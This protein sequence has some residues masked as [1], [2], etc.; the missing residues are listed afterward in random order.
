MTSNTNIANLTNNNIS[1][2]LTSI[3]NSNN[4]SNNNNN[5]RNTNNKS[6]TTSAFVTNRSNFNDER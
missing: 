6:P 3:S 4:N 5:N 2:D 1:G